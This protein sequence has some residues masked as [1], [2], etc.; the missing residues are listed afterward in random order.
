MRIAEFGLRIGERMMRCGRLGGWVFGCVWGVLGC[1]L[2]ARRAFEK[3]KN[4][5]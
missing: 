4:V 1:V 3:G 2:W 5:V